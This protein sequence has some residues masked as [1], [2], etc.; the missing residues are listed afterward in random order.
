MSHSKIRVLFAMRHTYLPQ[1]AGGSHSATHDLCVALM[2]RGIE[3]AVLAALSP[4]GVLGFRSRIIRKLLRRQFPVDRVMGYPVYRGWQPVDGVREVA[5]HFGPSVIIVQPGYPVPLVKAFLQLGL[6]TVFYAHDTMFEKWGGPP[7]DHPQLLYLANSR[8]TASRLNETFGLE[9]LVFP[10]FVRPDA[11][12]T[13][14]TRDRVVFVCPHPGKG[15]ELAF[16]LAESRPDLPFDF[17]ESWDMREALRDSYQARA[18]A[19]GNI[20]WK[21]RVSDMRKVYGEAKLVLVPSV[22]EEAWGRLATEAHVSGIPVLASNRGGLPEAVGPGGVLVDH[23]AP[24]SDWEQ[25]LA[26]MWDDSSEYHRLSEAALQYSA[27]K[28]MDPDYVIRRLLT[29]LTKHINACQSVSGTP[30]GDS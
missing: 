13:A 7:P 4:R 27:R 6:P 10:P 16:R 12:R 25:A 30:A 2:L 1:R 20:R 18:R 23:D 11:Y 22:H 19:A 3:P 14:T 8:F 21:A 17:V 24:F 5:K 9:A 15:A 28:E 29:V 26:R